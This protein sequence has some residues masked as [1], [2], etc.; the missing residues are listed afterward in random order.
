M[1]AKQGLY[2]PAYERDA[3]GVGLLININGRKSHKVIDDGLTV[4]EN[5]IHRGAEGADP[6]TGDGA[7]IMIQVPHEFILLQGYAVPEKGHYGTGLVFMPKDEK[8]AE[9]IMESFKVAAEAEG[10]EVTGFRD[11]P[12][13]NSMLGEGALAAEPMT[14]QVIVVEKELSDIA[15][16]VRLYRM[17][18]MVEKANHDTYVVSLS[19]LGLSN[20]GSSDEADP[21]T[22]FL[23]KPC[24]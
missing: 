10:L 1:S 12:V 14:K 16:D 20:L 7:G 2:D 3:C 18:R 22:T 17:R 13:D 15:L 19:T 5:M 6:A 8:R 21:T 4:L 24:S 23:C 11:V 9:E